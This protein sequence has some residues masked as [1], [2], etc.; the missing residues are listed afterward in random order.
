MSNLTFY[1]N[2]RFVDKEDAQISILDLG[3]V[4]GYGVF[5]FL[6]TYQ[7]KPFKLDEHLLRLQ[8][9]A[10]Q[11]GLQ[12]PPISQIRKITLQTLKKNA[13][14]EANIKIIVSGGETSDGITPGSK[15]TLAIL[16]Y[17]PTIYPKSFYESFWRE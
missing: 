5:D 10:K 14:P 8:A 9:S 2:G 12:I 6:R 3:F 11:I 13:L 16:V 15:P 1:L 7:G 17:P 4:R